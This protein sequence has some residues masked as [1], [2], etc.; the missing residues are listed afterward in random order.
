MYFFF[1]IVQLF[2]QY[3]PDYVNI[4][5]KILMSCYVSKS[6][7][8]SPGDRGIFFFYPFG[9]MFNSFS[10]VL[11]CIYNCILGFCVFKKIFIAISF[12]KF[13]D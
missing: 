2:F 1:Q 5:I 13:P 7:N 3:D 12:D 9:D 6:G 8:F 11:K 10:Y 4:N